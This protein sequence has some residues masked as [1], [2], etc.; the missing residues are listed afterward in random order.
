LMC[1]VRK[2]W[3]LTLVVN[4]GDL[5]NKVQSLQKKNA[6]FCKKKVQSCKNSA[7]NCKKGLKFCKKT[8]NLDWKLH[9]S[10]R[11]AIH[12]YPNSYRKKLKTPEYPEFLAF[13]E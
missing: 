12:R 5:Q 1:Y 6:D 4:I 11:H 10:I 8:S 13:L 7:D 3:S 9:F 2:T